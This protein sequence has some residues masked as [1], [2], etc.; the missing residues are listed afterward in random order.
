MK[1]SRVLIGLS[2][3]SLVLGLIAA[4]CGLFW[5][6]EGNSFFFTTLHGQEVEIFGRGIYRLDA[7]S[8]AATYIGTDAVTILLMAPLMIYALLRYRRGSLLGALLLACALSPLLYNSFH[9]AFAVAYNPLFLLYV[10]FFSTSLF[11]FL[12]A[13]ISIDQSVLAAQIS[14]QIPRRGPAVFLIVAG[15]ALAFVWL[16]DLI[17][18]ML[19]DQPPIALGSATTLVT[20]AFDLG[21]IVPSTLLAGILILRRSPLGYFLGLVLIVLNAIV[22]IVV[23]SQTI[24]MIALGVT[25]TPAMIVVF[26]APFILMAFFAAWFAMGILKHIED[27]PGLT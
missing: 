11:A 4:L 22:G 24:T 5:L 25:L 20:Y 21:V 10:A 7:F 19:Q 13:F 17:P 15:S 1:N 2:S 27:T 3:L 9:M 12:L 23:A 16:S 26:V 8:S 6:E 18:A 14:P